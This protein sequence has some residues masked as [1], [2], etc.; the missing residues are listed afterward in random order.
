M[1]CRH[2]SRVDRTVLELLSSNSRLVVEG[3]TAGAVAVLQSMVEVVAESSKVAEGVCRLVEV[4]MA[5]VT[6]VVVPVR[7]EVCMAVNSGF[8]EGV[9][10]L[11]VPRLSWRG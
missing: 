2:L 3:G 7:V 8:L 6:Q 4:V 9:G 1:W 11:W 10:S 5:E